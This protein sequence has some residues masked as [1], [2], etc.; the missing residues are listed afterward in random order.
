VRTACLLVG[1]VLPAAAQ[2][3]DGDEGK[4]PIE[5]LRILG[6]RPGRIE[7]DPTAFGDVLDVDAYTAESKD[8]PELLSEQAGV[9]VRRFGG[10]GDRSEVSIRGSTSQQVVV[11]IDGVRANSALTGGLDLSRVCL[12][13]LESVAIARGAG[14][15]REGSG[16]VGGVVDLLTRAGT[17][18]PET[19]IAASGGAFDTWQG[20]L[21]HAARVG[22]LDYH[23]GYCGLS[24]E[25][26]FEFERPTFVGPDGVSSTPVPD[27]AER[28]NNERTQ[29]GATLGLGARLGPGR[30]RFGDFLVHSQGGEPGLDDGT[31][32]PGAGQNPRADSRDWSNL[33]QLRYESDPLTRAHEGVVLGVYHRFEDS[34]YHD[35]LAP[36]ERP[37]GVG[38][39]LSTVGGRVTSAWQVALG[40]L[41]Q[42]I[43]VA[44]DAYQDALGSDEQRSRDRVTGAGQL[45]DELSLWDERV[46]LAPALRAEDSDGFD[47]EWVPGVGAVISPLP[48]LRLR[49]NAGRAYRVPN[50]DELYHPDQG[51]IRGNPDLEP[52]DAW[53]F[54]AGFEL[55]L[56]QLGP[57]ADVRL[58]A[59]YFRRE[60]DESI[61]WVKVSP[62][63][64]EPINTG[65]ATA[66]GAEIT[67]SFRVSESLRLSLNHTELDSERDATGKRLPGQP[68]RESFARVQ[69]GPPDAWKLVGE[70][71]RTDDI[72]VEEGGGSFLPDRTV[73]NAS[74]SVNLAALRWLPIARFVPE[75]WVFVDANNLSD[76]AVRDTLTFPQPGRNLTFGGEARW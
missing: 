65:E 64:V 49:A 26:D 53:N 42:R 24:T 9:F 7:A 12:P 68:E 60:I 8:L 6:V 48:W 56:A 44:L 31:P 50:F 69:I 11:A 17:G 13:L 76:E 25:G 21:F 37:S 22:P 33:A 2:A 34:D 39:R 32:G 52:E 16:A 1:L 15:T 40:P 18:E 71:H 14:A 75:L 61:V 47:L 30:L 35:P 70:W 66:Q 27:H 46:L 28:I 62:T 3:G 63:T 59:G 73:W 29:H 54:D 43:G 74:L 20:S 10:V 38:A 58:V 4:A 5:E 19:R 45:L 41:S 55:L 36:F 51:Y 72:L 57:L 67:L 23:A